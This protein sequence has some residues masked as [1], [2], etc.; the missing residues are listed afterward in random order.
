MFLF[1]FTLERV[2]VLPDVYFCEVAARERINDAAIAVTVLCADL[3]SAARPGQFLHVKCGDGLLL[4]RPFGVCSVSG[5]ALSFVFEVKGK[6][7]G[8]LSRLKP[9]DV[10]DILGPLGNGF[11]FPDGKIIVVG[12]GL[13]SPPM[14]FVAESAK[15]GATA[16]LGFR[17][18]GRVMLV[19]EFEAVCDAV[20]LTTDDGSMGICGQVTAP[21]EGL[22]KKGGYEAVMACGQLAMQNAV[23]KLCERYGVPCQVSLEERMGCGVGACL[24]CAC[25]IREGG[26]EHMKRVCKDGP[27]FDAKDVVFG[28]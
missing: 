21:L 24:V 14:L 9:G 10:L 12:G 27:V 13:G 16:V 11:C 26:N 15:R 20:Y 2:V 4:R 3:A 23:A 18:K 22:L 17:D 19:N 5:G 8:W 28:V 6:G 25:A 1:M 7:T